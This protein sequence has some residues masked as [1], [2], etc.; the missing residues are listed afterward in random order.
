MVTVSLRSLEKDYVQRAS[1]EELL[2][3]PWLTQNISKNYLRQYIKMI[4]K[5]RKS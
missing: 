1:V 2:K 4:K 3:H 5:H